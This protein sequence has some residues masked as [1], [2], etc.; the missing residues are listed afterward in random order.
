MPEEMMGDR[1]VSQRRPLQQTTYLRCLGMPVHLLYLNPAQP[2]Q[3]PKLN[4]KDH[5]HPRGQVPH[6]L[7]QHIPPVHSLEG[8]RV[9]NLQLRA[10][11]RQM[12]QGLGQ[13]RAYF[14]LNTL[15]HQTL[16]LK[17]T[18]GFLRIGG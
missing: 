12:Y 1:L 2:P 5:N 3:L 9:G 14:L 18:G 10:E 8:F 6:S 4:I 11:I 7:N 16:V 15:Q 17:L 13:L